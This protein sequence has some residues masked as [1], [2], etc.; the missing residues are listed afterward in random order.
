M[1][2]EKGHLPLNVRR[3]I[4]NLHATLKNTYRDE[5]LAI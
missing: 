3:N 4:S 5:W 2:A 1:D